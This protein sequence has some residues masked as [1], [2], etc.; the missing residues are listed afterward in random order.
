MRKPKP[1]I[2]VFFI[3]LCLTACVLCVACKDTTEPERQP[4]TETEWRPTEGADYTIATPM[5]DVRFS[6][7]KITGKM[8]EKTDTATVSYK[9]TYTLYPSYPDAVHQNP[10][11][12]E[13]VQLSFRYGN[14]GE[15]DRPPVGDEKN[16]YIDDDFSKGPLETIGNSVFTHFG[17]C[18]EL[19]TT[20][21]DYQAKTGHYSFPSNELHNRCGTVD[22]TGNLFTGS[23][24]AVTQDN[25]QIADNEDTPVKLNP[26]KDQ[27][28]KPFTRLR[29]NTFL[30]LLN[31][32]PHML[33][34]ADCAALNSKLY[35]DEGLWILAETLNLKIKENGVWYEIGSTVNPSTFSHVLFEIENTKV[36]STAS[37]SDQVYVDG[38]FIELRS[39]LKLDKSTVTE[40]RD[41][42]LTVKFYKDLTLTDF[43]AIR[44]RA[45]G[46][47]TPTDYQITIPSMNIA[48]ID[49]KCAETTLTLG[50]GDG[51]N[52]PLTQDELTG[53]M[54]V[55]PYGKPIAEYIKEFSPRYSAPT[56]QTVD[57][58]I[59]TGQ[60][61][62]T[63]YTLTEAFGYATF[64]D[65]T[66]LDNTLY[67]YQSFYVPTALKI[68]EHYYKSYPSYEAQTPDRT[69]TVDLYEGLF[70]E[71]TLAPLGVGQKTVSLV[72]NGMSNPEKCDTY[73][74]TVLSDT[75]SEI[76][77]ELDPLFSG[78]VIGEPVDLTDCFINVTFMHDQTAKLPLT[79]DM[80]GSYNES[81][82]GEQDVEI[83]YRESV[84]KVTMLIRKVKSFSVYEGL[85]KTYLL[86]DE[87]SFDDVWLTVK[88]VD[89]E[90]E[91]YVRVPADRFMDFD[92]S[93]PGNRSF[94]I[95]YGGVSKSFA[96]SVIE[97]VYITYTVNNGEIT[98]KSF[99]TGIPEEGVTAFIPEDAKNIALPETIDDLPVTAAAA[100]LFKGQSILRTLV[101]PASIG[102]I[103]A[104]M[105]DGCRNLEKL[106]VSGAVQLKNYFTPYKY[107]GFPNK[108]TYPN[109]SSKLE[110]VITGEILCD[111]FF[112]D[113][114]CAQSNYIK[115]LTLGSNLTDFGTQSILNAVKSFTNGGSRTVYALDDVVYTD[116][117]RKLYYY[118]QYKTSEA[119][120]IPSTVRE[121]CMDTNE[122]IQSLTVP[123]GVTTLGEMF[124]SDCD[125]LTSV[126]F[127]SGSQVTEL[128]DFAF[129]GCENLTTFVFPENLTT[130][131][132]SVMRYVGLEKIIL[133]QSVSSVGNQAFF[134]AKCTHFY[135]PTAA[136]QGFVYNQYGGHN[137][138]I[139][140]NLVAV[141]YDGTV[142]FAKLTMMADS[143]SR[144]TVELY[145]TGEKTNVGNRWYSSASA[146]KASK[147][148]VVAGAGFNRHYYSENNVI[149]EAQG[150]SFTK[151][152]L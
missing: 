16:G 22:E 100:N 15:E 87:P 86:N 4:G 104:G 145:I 33:A 99:M 31:D 36:Y 39:G 130:I 54:T 24:P 13:T 72:K 131:G 110:V 84:R 134:E 9:A 115:K 109:I 56:T 71:L 59:P 114:Y 105:V 118:S 32:K 80:L 79:E 10:Y 147:I 124:M 116:G 68:N 11:K 94:L 48:E 5:V 129:D 119:F 78:I 140:P 34:K 152:W 96:Y 146:Q 40:V 62:E 97:G 83:I 25:F 51:K 88:F 77:V 67:E 21:S 90:D 138:I 64:S 76:L 12:T 126:T 141:A 91:D 55:N 74:L 61:I 45:D 70:D 43:E 47:Q 121:V 150:G 58:E 125:A 85:D 20:Y 128:P 151:W 103:G 17:Y 44:F 82:L 93:E 41:N 53:E 113:L 133:P 136:T 122:Y 137:F 132:D 63:E 149:D 81:R 112:A 1:I 92:L 139:L 46:I 142:E 120:T 52:I 49:Q 57:I 2:T 66:L 135:I 98:L 148:Y 101:V 8:G 107:A 106:T 7:I 37:L 50:Y 73:N 143:M 35:D 111:D 69:E 18:K 117:G 65:K 19:S 6:D 108:P 102:N 3:L 29:F 14:V 30:S 23:R 26:F 42:T 38:N 28:L 27:E 127:E 144:Q 60:K 75:V 89:E 95:T 123:A